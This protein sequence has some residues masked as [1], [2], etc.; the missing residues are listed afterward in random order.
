MAPE[1]YPDETIMGTVRFK[2]EKAYKAKSIQVGFCGFQE[3]HNHEDKST[4]KTELLYNQK[5]TLM[6]F[7]NDEPPVGE[8]Q[9][10]PFAIK[11]PPKDDLQKPSF[12]HRMGHIKFSILHGLFAQLE[13]VDPKAYWFKNAKILAQI[14]TRTPLKLGRQ[15]VNVASEEHIV[16]IEK[17]L[18]GFMGIGKKLSTANLVLP[19]KVYY[20]GERAP[21]ELQL[22]NSECSKDL[23]RVELTVYQHTEFEIY[24]STSGAPHATLK[25][26]LSHKFPKQFL[27]GVKAG[28]SQAA[29]YAMK[30]PQ[31]VM[32]MPRNPRVPIKD[33]EVW[34]SRMIP[35]S[36]QYSFGV[37]KSFA[38]SYELKVRV[39]HDVWGSDHKQSIAFVPIKIIASES[40]PVDRKTQ[41]GVP[42]QVMNCAEEMKLMAFGEPGRETAF[43][44][45]DADTEIEGDGVS[46]FDQ[47]PLRKM[48]LE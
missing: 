22:F 19:R 24:T 48:T 16:T 3:F 9:E 32:D 15:A 36:F 20:V 41:H 46:I 25:K 11:V 12:C 38:V 29:R 31:S 28:A 18:G 35:P 13:P 37:V 26:K 45:Q 7:E 6:V 4:S 14:S 30:I 21:T 44:K 42:L 5:Q 34:L 8:E 47:L 17:E 23:D 43:L 2:L 39:C 33:E 40:L 1:F 10:Y 27:P